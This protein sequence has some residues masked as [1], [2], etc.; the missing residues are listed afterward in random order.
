MTA[1]PKTDDS[2]VVLCNKKN[3]FNKKIRLKSESD[4][5][6]IK[7]SSLLVG[8][9]LA[10][11]AKAIQPGV[12]L[13]YLDRLAETYIRD[14]QAVPSFK[15][16]NGFPASLCLSVNDV[17]VHGIP[18][19]YTLREGDIV[20]V[21]CGVYKNGFHGD[22]CYTFPVGHIAEDRKLLLKH[23]KESLYRGIA[24]AQ[25]GNT[26][27]DIG[28]AVQSYVEQFGYGVVRE[29]C[30]H[31]IGRDLHEKP[32]VCNYGKMGKGDELREGMVI[33]IEPMITMKSHK[34]YV[35]KD[36]W[37]VRTKDGQPAAHFEHQVAI[38]KNG[39]EV[40]ST[41]QYIEEVLGNISV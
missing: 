8:K 29:L 11:V 22:Y 5:E 10:E 33:C 9:T 39:T 26:T 23:T 18:N 13:L 15:N 32:D 14:N 30:G 21:D 37:T 36:E 35:E 16:Y 41:Y 4:I 6:L 19:N 2:K 1:C 7:I 17:V 12:P 25:K 40:L 24:A 20:S 27:G 28:Y 38:T 3:M 31:G 34:V